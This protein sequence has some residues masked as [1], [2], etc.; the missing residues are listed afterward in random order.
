MSSKPR[1]VGT[2]I[3]KGDPNM[4][5]YVVDEIADGVPG[6]LF[7]TERAYE[8]MRG[9]IAPPEVTA[10]AE[11]APTNPEPVVLQK[12]FQHPPLACQWI[13]S[14]EGA[15]VF[16]CPRCGEERTLSIPSKID[17][18]GDV[19]PAYRCSN[20]PTHRYLKLEDWRPN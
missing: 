16:G 7:L 17:E 20:C 19:R 8:A 15:I 4:H 18:N 14:P 10:A 6:A 3:I 5:V 13:A 11:S 1:Y 9:S 2:T 12:G